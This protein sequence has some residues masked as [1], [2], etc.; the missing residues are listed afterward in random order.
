M[1]RGRSG[2]AVF[3]ISLLAG[4]AASI[5]LISPLATSP[6]QHA[7]EPAQ[8]AALSDPS[9]VAALRGSLAAYGRLASGEPVTDFT[10]QGTITYFWAGQQVQGP[11]V[12]RG[13]APDEFRLDA[14]LPQGTRSYT[15]SHGM[16]WLR[17]FD[18]TV[19]Q[20]A[21]QNTI[22]VGT[23]A[24]PAFGVVARLDEPFTRIVEMGLSNKTGQPLHDVRVYRGFSLASN[25]HDGLAELCV[26]DYLLDP[27]TNLVVATIDQTHPE[28]TASRSYEHEIDLENYAENNGVR[29]PMLIREKIDGQTTWQLQLSAI[30]FN[31]GLGDAEFTLQ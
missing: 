19:R 8:P 30:S 11:A 28:E 10:A 22:N 24:F 7:A 13:R 3:P 1:T 15:L 31:T 16:G 29:A 21:L 14:N 20:L 5:W 4:L 27:A 26:T 17:T 18:G 25:R 2:V 6:A 9:A 12:V 23:I